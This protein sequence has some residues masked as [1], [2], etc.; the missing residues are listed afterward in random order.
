MRFVIWAVRLVVFVLVL[1]FA[2]KNTEPVDVGLYADHM[3][4][5]VP[6]IVVMLIAFAVGAVCA[7]LFVMPAS[8]RRRRE[9][10]R[11]RREVTRLREEAA[12][13]HRDEDAVVSHDA[14][15][16]LAPL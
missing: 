8:M 16:P 7:V 13:Q 2:L 5:G 14:A 1:L 12:R 4:R 6:L 3:I 10:T 15:P 9:A 11:L